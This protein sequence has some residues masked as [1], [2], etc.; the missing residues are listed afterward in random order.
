MLSGML[1]NTESARA[2]GNAYLCT[3]PCDADRAVLERA[4]CGSNPCNK[5]F[6]D[7]PG[8]RAAVMSQVRSDY[9]LGRVANVEGWILSQTEAR[10][11]ALVT[12]TQP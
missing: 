2:V 3:N 12:M 6:I 7:Q 10:L 11:C 4:L 8:L 5:Q 1:G 9:E